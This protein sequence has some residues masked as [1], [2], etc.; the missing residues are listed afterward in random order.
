MAKAKK[1]ATK[2]K[3]A[4]SKAK[5]TSKK[6]EEVIV[7]KRPKVLTVNPTESI[8]DQMIDYWKENDQEN[9]LGMFGN[10]DYSLG[11]TDIMQSGLPTL[12]K[13]I[14]VKLDRSCCG[15]PIGKMIEIFGSEASAKT[16]FML[17]TACAIIKNGGIAFFVDFENKFDPTWL[18]TIAV[19]HGLSDNDLKRFLYIRPDHFE[20]FM[21]WMMK[22]MGVIV[23]SKKAAKVALIKIEKKSG[24]KTETEIAMIAKYKKDI[25]TPYAMFVDSVAAIYTEK[26][27]LEKEETTVNVALLARQFAVKLKLV[28]TMIK[29]AKTLIVWANQE[30][31]K[32]A[33]G[34]QKVRPGMM[35][36]PGGTA[37]KYNCEARIR[38]SFAKA[39]KR[40]RNGVERTYGSVYKFR[41]VKN[42]MGIPPFAEAFLRMHYDRGFYSFHSILTACA[43]EGIIKKIGSRFK[44][45]LQKYGVLDFEESATDEIEREYAGYH[46]PKILLNIYNRK[47]AGAIT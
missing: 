2:K 18:K 40:T 30:R 26:E 17:Y 42:Q 38:M 31:H 34:G 12:E 1:K 22:A 19:Y 35:V 25:D 16:T 27:V 4:A 6:E 8:S 29:E 23:S 20:W 15:M 44:I 21:M 14:A 33:M 24:K 46:L 5:K 7:R 32:I 28:R 36:T 9:V 10:E 45:D 47:I 37:I 11:V 41:I 3:K 39:L 43:D 13:C